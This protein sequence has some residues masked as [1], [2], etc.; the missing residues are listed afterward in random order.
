V[1]KFIAALHALYKT[2]R[3]T[4]QL[5]T[6]ADLVAWQRAYSDEASHLFRDEV[7]HGSDLKSAIL[8]KQHLVA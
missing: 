7:D 5:S 4:R 1:I 3:L 6:R 2:K 8:F